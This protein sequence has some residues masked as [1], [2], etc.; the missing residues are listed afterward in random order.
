MFIQFR[1]KH[2]KSCSYSS[3][4]SIINL[5]HPCVLYSAPKPWNDSLVFLE[6]KKKNTCF[7]SWINLV[8]WDSRIY[9]TFNISSLVL[10]IQYLQGY[11][12]RMI[13]QRRPKTQK[14]RWFETWLLASAFNWVFWWFT[15]W[16]STEFASF[17]LQGILNARKRTKKNSV[18]SSLKSHPLWLTLYIK[19]INICTSISKCVKSAF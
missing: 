19:C 8:I 16:L 5:V 11:P 1:F 4:S 18:Q 9:E 12:R 3:V 15:E 10:V 6:F 17:G 7:L 14:I 2:Y 13:L